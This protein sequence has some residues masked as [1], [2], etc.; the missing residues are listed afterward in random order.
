LPAKPAS[1][2]PRE[3]LV[4]GFD[5]EVQSPVHIPLVRAGRGRG[6]LVVFERRGAEM[7][8]KRDE[9]RR[10]GSLDPGA[11]V[12]RKPERQAETIPGGL[13]RHDDRVAANSTQPGPDTDERSPAGHR[14][15]PGA[16]DDAVREAGQRR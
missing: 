2:H 14:D 9:P 4:G 1:P 12:G 10:P 3:T 6:K 11:Y 13:S 15:G 8:D 16:D 5:T 7:P